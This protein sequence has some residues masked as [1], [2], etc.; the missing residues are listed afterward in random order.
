MRDRTKT[1]TFIPADPGMRLAT[2]AATIALATGGLL[3]AWHAGSELRIGWDQYYTSPAI[4]EVLSDEAREACLESGMTPSEV[5]TD[6]DVCLARY[7]TVSRLKLSERT[8]IDWYAENG[9]E[10]WCGDPGWVRPLGHDGACELGGRELPPFP[11]NDDPWWAAQ[12]VRDPGRTTDA[13]LWAEGMNPRIGP[14]MWRPT[15]P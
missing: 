7:W 14:S 2:G 3:V 12:A 11:A 13:A 6:P 5:A 15:Q 10:L 1:R 9:V 4:V 8:R